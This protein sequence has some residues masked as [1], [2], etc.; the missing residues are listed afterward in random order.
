MAHGEDLQSVVGP[1]ELAKRR[2]RQVAGFGHIKLGVPDADNQGA[3]RVY[4]RAER[5]RS[6][7]L[8][9]ECRWLVLFL[10]QMPGQLRTA[11]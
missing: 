4:L 10:C 3:P 1:A 8:G 5:D 6:R 9:S 2:L 11:T 7:L